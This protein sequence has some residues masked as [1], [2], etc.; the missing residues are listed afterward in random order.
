MTNFAR[1]ER[2]AL[3]AELRSAGPD[4]PTLCEGW[5]AKD[6]AIHIV[7]RDRY[8]LSLP[9]NAFPQFADKVPWLSE[10]SKKTAAHLAELP[11]N[12]IVGMV[13]GG[14]GMLSPMSLE[15]IDH[16][17]N[18]AEFYVHHEDVRRAGRGFAPRNLPHEF[19]SQCW[20]I[21][22][23][24]AKAPG[25]HADDPVEFVADGFGEVHAGPR[26]AAATVVSGKPSELLLYA[27]GRRDRANVE[28]TAPKKG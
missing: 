5:D 19:E 15:P 3:A 11:W 26:D 9:G 27:F 24:I 20:K 21:V 4:A 1:S 16:L 17:A 18:T 12:E 25:A 8:P 23:A 7:I 10:R 6:L 2:L 13:A 22:S 28:I 14:P